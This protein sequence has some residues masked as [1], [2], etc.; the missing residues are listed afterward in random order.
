MR[1]GV[2]RINR[3][4]SWRRRSWN[5]GRGRGGSCGGC[6]RAWTAF[7]AHVVRRVVA[8]DVSF[9][10]TMT[11]TKKER[12]ALAALAVSSG[13]WMF[14]GEALV[15]TSFTSTLLG[16]MLHLLFL[17]SLLR[18]C[19]STSNRLLL[20]VDTR[21]WGFFDC[22]CWSFS[23]FRRGGRGRRGLSFLHGGRS[24]LRRLTARRRKR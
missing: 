16:R 7:G 18:R 17:R 3:S 4:N 19:I 8:G 11:V 12:G 13:P 1:G 21:R 2:R 5:R 20:A 14:S 15:G 9:V 23:R 10:L 24:G 6:G 22:S